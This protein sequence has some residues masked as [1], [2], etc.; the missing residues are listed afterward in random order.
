[1]TTVIFSEKIGR[2]VCRAGLLPWFLVPGVHAP[3]PNVAAH[4]VEAV[5]VRLEA[6]HGRGPRESIVV[7]LD[8]NIR[9]RFFSRVISRARRRRPPGAPRIHIGDDHIPFGGRF[10]R[11]LRKAH[12][13]APLQV[14]RQAVELI[15]RKHSFLLFLI[16]EPLAPVRQHI[17]QV[18]AAFNYARR[19]L[20]SPLDI[21]NGL[22]YKDCV[23]VIDISD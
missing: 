3:L 16:R 17:V 15:R 8:R 7:S 20:I 13:F 5:L 9:S 10:L 22:W 14:G 23:K 4:I 2:G 11:F 12:G 6:P 19:R 18:G 21:A 1:M